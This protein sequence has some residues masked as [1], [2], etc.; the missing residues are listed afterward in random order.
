[1]QTLVVVLPLNAI[2]VIAFIRPLD[3]SV[4]R[5]IVVALG[6]V[7]INLLGVMIREIRVLVVTSART[8]LISTTDFWLLEKWLRRKQIAV[9]SVNIKQRQGKWDACQIESASGT[10]R[11]LIDKRAVIPL[12][13]TGQ[14][15]LIAEP[16]EM[17]TPASN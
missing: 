8:T 3:M 14:A 9:L 13:D 2:L 7:G 11:Y 12:L 10:R 1:M 6:I 15:T 17:A 5:T 16:S 4:S